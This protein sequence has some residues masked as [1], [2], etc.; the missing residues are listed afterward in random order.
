MS[1]PPKIES[2]FGLNSATK[3]LV[4]VSAP[5]LGYPDI[6]GGTFLL[7][8]DASSDAIG[9]VLSQ[10][11]DGKEKLIAYDSK[12]YCQQPREIAVSRAKKS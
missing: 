8:T 4:L 6:S 2:G 1:S 9:A 7:D 5:I 10:V 3:R 11:Q 12:I